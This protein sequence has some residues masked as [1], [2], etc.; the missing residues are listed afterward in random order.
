MCSSIAEAAYRS[1]VQEKAQIEG[2]NLKVVPNGWDLL[3]LSQERALEIC[4]EEKQNNYMSES[5]EI[6]GS[7]DL[8]LNSRGQRVDDDGNL[9]DAKDIES[10]ERSEAMQAINAGRAPASGS[11]YQCANCGFVVYVPKNQDFETD[12]PDD[13]ICFECRADKKQFMLMQFEDTKEK[14]PASDS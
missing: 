12:F 7:G 10:V 9:V 14:K 4:K 11:A 1:T 13:Y 3:G 5:M 6:Y 8:N 2:G